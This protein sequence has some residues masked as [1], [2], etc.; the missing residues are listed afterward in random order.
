MSETRATVSRFGEEAIEAGAEADE[1]RLIG[2]IDDDG[3]DD[4]GN[5]TD[6]LETAVA[7]FEGSREILALLSPPR[8]NA[9]EAEVIK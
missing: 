4:K 3:V 8:D 2:L 1:M 6:D 7:A 9:A 5:D